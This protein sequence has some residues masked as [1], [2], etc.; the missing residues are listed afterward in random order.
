MRIYREHWELRIRPHNE[1]PIVVICKDRGL[2]EKELVKYAKNKWDDIPK[3]V[4]SEKHL[5]DYLGRDDQNDY[6]TWEF[7]LVKSI[8]G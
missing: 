8:V 2:L 5:R 1:N 6:M 4:V 3:T 7:S